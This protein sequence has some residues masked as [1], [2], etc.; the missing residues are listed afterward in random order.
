MT[1]VRRA[2][3]LVRTAR[4]LRWRQWLYRPLRRVQGRFPAASAAA[5]AVDA[6]RAA[7]LLAAVR[8]EGPGDGAARIAR[9]DAVLEGRFDFVGH[10]LRLDPVDWRTRHV[11]ALWT[12]NLHYFDYAADLAWAFD[13]TGDERYVRGFEALAGSWIAAT[14]DGRGTAWDPYPVSL[15]VVNWTRALVLLGGAMDAGART[16]VERSLHRQLRHLERRL[17]WHVLANHL[18]KNLHALVV[19]GLL[20]SGPDAARWRAR[21]LALLWRELHEQVLDDGAHYERSPM[22]HAIALGDFLELLSFFDACAVEVPAAAR[23]RVR[24]MAAAW[25]RLSRASG[26]PHLFNDSA[27]GIAPAGDELAKRTGAA[28][29]AQPAPPHG[30][31]A[32][33][34]GG[35]FGWRGAAG[36]DAMIVD[37]G[38]PGPGYQPGHA[39]CDALSFELDL[40]GVPVVVDSGVSGY[41]GDP[42]RA[43]VRSTRAHNTVAIGGREQSEVWGTFRVARMAE[44]RALETPVEG[45]AEFRFRGECRPYHD[46]SAAHVRLVAREG[47]GWR[48]EDRVEG[49]PGAALHSFV[50][51]H[52]AFTAEVEGSRVVARSDRMRVTI[53]THGA[54]AVRVGRGG[55]GAAEGWYA[56]RFG[57]AVPAPVVMLEVAANDGRAFG[58]TIRGGER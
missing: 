24:R 26:E 21:G 41:E 32:L 43:Y 57:G 50:H 1:P 30:C 23:E 9:A 53:D 11:S 52:P 7:A 20:F 39:H 47:D 2:L 12:Y 17:E 16:T 15:R 6:G 33:P 19:G 10:A 35:F 8:A 42:L 37:C 56:A 25:T 51:L 14:A 49:A 4:R 5:A 45:S 29:G 55:E 48:I 34:A 46:R 18:Q 3:L 40:G 31:W 22:Y 58:Y 54:D 38:E 13:L 28:L 27:E 36:G 44:V